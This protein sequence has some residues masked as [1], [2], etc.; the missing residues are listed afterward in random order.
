MP[1]YAFCL[2]D[3]GCGQH[4]YMEPILIQGDKLAHQKACSCLQ[5]CWLP[6]RILW[7]YQSWWKSFGAS[8]IRHH[9]NHSAHA[10]H[11]ASWF[12]W[13]QTVCVQ[14]AFCAATRIVFT[15]LSGPKIPSARATSPLRL[16]ET[17]S[18]GCF[19]TLPGKVLCITYLKKSCVLGYGRFC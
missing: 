12:W 19:R 5:G 10:R 3:Y 13:L 15:R 17:S 18:S 1:G 16:L 11:A 14:H 8:R 6:I 9:C 2:K 4:V 7:N